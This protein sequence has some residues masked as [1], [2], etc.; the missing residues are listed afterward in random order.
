[1]SS[2]SRFTLASHRDRSGLSHITPPH[3]AQHNRTS[4]THSSQIHRTSPQNILP[5]IRR[6]PSPRIAAYPSFLPR[7]T[8]PTAWR[9]EQVM[10]HLE[11]L[12]RLRNL[13]NI[14]NPSTFPPMP[15]NLLPESSFSLFR[16][17]MPAFPR[18]PFH[19]STWPAPQPIKESYSP[20]EKNKEAS[21]SHPQAA[22][23]KT[24][25]G[26]IVE[27]PKSS[28][29]RYLSPP[30]LTP[31]TFAEGSMAVGQPRYPAHF[32]RGSLIQLYNGK[33]KQ[34]EHLVMEDFCQSAEFSP[35]VT[36]DH[37]TVT[38]L[39][40]VADTR[41]VLLNFSKKKIQ[42][43]VEAASEHPFFVIG[44]GWS[45]SNPEMTLTR[46]HLNCKQLRV[47]DVCISLKRKASNYH[48]SLLFP[49]AFSTS[50]RR[51]TSSSTPSKQVIFHDTPSIIQFDPESPP[52]S[53]LNPEE[54]G[55]LPPISTPSSVENNV[56]NVQ[57]PKRR[58]TAEWENEHKPNKIRFNPTK[59]LA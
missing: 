12:T 31:S 9:V 55:M 4:P 33:M 21:S 14:N 17:G 10:L 5:F 51:R 43:T 32:T 28:A 26:I 19:P 3:P 24:A 41:T 37:S 42:V 2:P 30:H 11:L 1:M 29:L 39:E 44:Q 27:K 13:I 59:E 50:D 15:N 18:L 25:S 54:G 40:L 46:Y 47:G 56:I 20:M 57:R 53:R 45:S 6:T 34:M 7:S 52:I 16:P 8:T 36:I 38:K 23:F 58:W 22:T 48:S 35:D 49:S